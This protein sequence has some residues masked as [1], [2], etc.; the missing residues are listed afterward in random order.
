MS[1]SAFEFHRPSL[2]VTGLENVQTFFDNVLEKAKDRICVCLPCSVVKYDRTKHLADLRVLFNWKMADGSV[3]EGWV[4]HNITVRRLLAG[5]FLI[6]FP[7]K[8]GDTGWIFATDYDAKDSK[9]ESKPRLPLT[10]FKNSYSSGFWIPDQW[11]ND[12]KL[13]VSGVDDGR[14]TIQTADGTQKVSIG[15]GDIHIT[16]AKVTI[17]AP[18]TE[19]TGNVKIGGDVE[20]GGKLDVKGKI[21]EIDANVT[22]STHTHTDSRGGNTSAPTS[23]T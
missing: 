16:S 2:D 18:E 23:G 5:G 14:L 10:P 4:I 12:E 17:T 9:A 15:S 6:D 13:G 1:A 3:V 8:E 20:M 19:I 21:K 11:G 7:I 22:M